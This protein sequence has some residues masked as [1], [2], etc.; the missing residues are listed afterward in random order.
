M[1]ALVRLFVWFNA[2]ISIEAY[3]VVDPTSPTLPF[4]LF[5]RI[6]P[7]GHAKSIGL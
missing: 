4:S 6:E 2:E 3:S 7:T 5:A 1:I